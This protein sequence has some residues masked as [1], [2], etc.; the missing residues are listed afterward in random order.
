M[1]VGTNAADMYLM[2]Y[3]YDN[4]L[5]SAGT[6]TVATLTQAAA[7]EIRAVDW[8][9]NYK[10]AYFGSSVGLLYVYASTGGSPIITL[11]TT[12]MPINTVSVT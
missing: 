6:V 10:Q 1:A 8:N 4:S 5:A 9:D 7:G 11:N 2:R 3:T 12:T